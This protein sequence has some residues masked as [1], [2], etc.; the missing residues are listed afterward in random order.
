LRYNKR[1]HKWQWNA[2]SET[3]PN[4]TAAATPTSSRCLCLRPPPAINKSKTSLVN[5][6]NQAPHRLK[7]I[8]FYDD[9]L[10]RHI[11]EDAGQVHTALVTTRE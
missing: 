7:N 10:A 6:E 3:V 8:V 1:K 5:H 4:T 11:E 9:A 2:V